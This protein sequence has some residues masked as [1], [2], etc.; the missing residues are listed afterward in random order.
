MN[1]IKSKTVTIKLT[2]LQHDLVSTLAKTH[3]ITV[4]EVFRRL[5]TKKKVHG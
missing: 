1:N 3:E 2:H 5:L 4:S